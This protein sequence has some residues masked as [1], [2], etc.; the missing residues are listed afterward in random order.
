MR[1]EQCKIF[2]YFNDLLILFEFRKLLLLLFLSYVLK[3]LHELKELIKFLE[4]LI[5]EV[6][7]ILVVSIFSLS[8]YFLV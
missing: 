4:Q 7:E 1:F 8:I 5:L 3:E 6:S 2:L